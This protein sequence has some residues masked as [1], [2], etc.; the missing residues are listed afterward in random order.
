MISEPVQG[1]QKLGNSGIVAKT[2]KVLA[3]FLQLPGRIKSYLSGR[4]S[5]FWIPVAIVA[6][7]SIL[8]SSILFMGAVI[9]GKQEDRLEVA[10]FLYISGVVV[11]AGPIVFMATAL[12]SVRA[13]LDPHYSEPPPKE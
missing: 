1:R 4:G 3:W 6:I 13:W 7:C 9:T 11:L 10:V 8:A 5:W 2:V 12:D